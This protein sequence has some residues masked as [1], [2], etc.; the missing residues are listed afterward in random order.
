MIPEYGTISVFSVVACKR[1]QMQYVPVQLPCG[2]V[3]MPCGPVIVD[4]QM[5]KPRNAVPG[6]ARLGSIKEG[7]VNFAAATAV[8]GVAAEKQAL[9]RLIRPG[10]LDSADGDPGGSR[11]AAAAADSPLGTLLLLQC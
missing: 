10:E 6:T 9:R 5:P 7:D 2:P 3:Q 1:I 11:S 8:G 4:V